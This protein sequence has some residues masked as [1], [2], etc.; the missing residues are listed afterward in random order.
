AA[1]ATAPGVDRRARRP[2]GAARR[3]RLRR[4]PAPPLL[5]RPRRVAAA[6]P[7]DLPRRGLL[8]PSSS[9]RP[10]EGAR[11]VLAEDSP[12][13]A[14]ATPRSAARGTSTRGLLPTVPGDRSP[15]EHQERR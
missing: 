9:P 15:D 8:T 7:P 4:Q 1:G 14:G 11:V 10:G 13:S 12:S 6:L 2:C 3:L 5:A